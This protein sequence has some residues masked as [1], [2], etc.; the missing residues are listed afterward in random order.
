MQPQQKN[1]YLL[2]FIDDVLNVIEGH[3]TY[4]FLNGY[5]VYHQIFIT[6]KEKYKTTFVTD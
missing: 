5:F 6:P 2:P 1:P 4:S 3:D